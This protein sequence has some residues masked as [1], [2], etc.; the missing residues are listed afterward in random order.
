[1]TTVNYL[2]EIRG[3]MFTIYRTKNTPRNK[4][5]SGYGSKLPTNYMVRLGNRSYRVY[6]ICWS[7]CAGHYITI[8]GVKYFLRD[9]DF[10]CN[11]AKYRIIG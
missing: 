4:S 6:A 2:G 1:M 8:S 7:N 9:G 3:D 10:P 5:I 11:G